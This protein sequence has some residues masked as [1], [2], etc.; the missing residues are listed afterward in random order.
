MPNFKKGQKV[1]RVI[2]GAGV[3]TASIAVVA[4][5]S[6][7]GEVRLD[8]DSSLTYSDFHGHEID[9]VIPG[10]TSEIIPLEE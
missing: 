7:K 9:P 10:F 8:G 6:K 1:V 3:K 2:H 5:V 4:R